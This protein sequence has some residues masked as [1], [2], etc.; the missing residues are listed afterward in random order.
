MAPFH[1]RAPGGQASSASA[2]P[3][4]LPADLLRA[5][6]AQSVGALVFKPALLVALTAAGLGIANAVAQDDFSDPGYQPAQAPEFAESRAI[7]ARVRHVAPPPSDLPTPAETSALKGCS[8]EA[9]FYGIGVRRDPVKARKCAFVER[10]A[11]DTRGDPFNGEAMLMTIYANGV[12]ARRNLDLAAHFACTRTEAAPVDTDTLVKA[13]WER[14]SQRHP[15]PF[16]YCRDVV[17]GTS[18][19]SIAECAAFESRRK[20]VDRDRKLAGLT[21]GWSRKDLVSYRTLLD[22]EAAYI[23]ARQFGERGGSVSDRSLVTAFADE[24]LDT[25]LR[26][27]QRLSTGKGPKATAQDLAR[28]DRLLNESYRAIMHG[29]PT[30]DSAIVINQPRVRQAQRAW[31]AY[32]EAWTDLVRQRWPSASALGV[33]AFLTRQRARMLFCMDHQSDDD[34]RYSACR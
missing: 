34:E 19:V 30:E 26:L 8:S 2:G 27:I 20:A 33:A 12:G 5:F 7:C 22:R 15:E 18:N 24:V 13:L 21:A 23:S 17:Q 11:G 28:A 6:A 14:K 31:L 1:S 16:D 4:A 3:L 25:R 9:L 29:L 10:R 32:R